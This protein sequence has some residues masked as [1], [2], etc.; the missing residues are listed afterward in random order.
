MELRVILVLAG[1]AAP[2]GMGSGCR[3]ALEQGVFYPLQKLEKISPHSCVRLALGIV[4]GNIYFGLAGNQRTFDLLVPEVNRSKTGQSVA[5]VWN[6]RS[7]SPEKGFLAV[8]GGWEHSGV[9]RRRQGSRHRISHSRS[10]T[11]RCF[12]TGSC[13]WSGQATS[14]PCPG[15]RPAVFVR[16]TPARKTISSVGL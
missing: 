11:L 16:P 13:V 15:L 1:A 14:T 8:F 9:C 10:T 3:S 7:H 6:K 2:S 12:R 5:E 4:F